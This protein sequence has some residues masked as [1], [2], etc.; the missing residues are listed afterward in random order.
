MANFPCQ[1][2]PPC[3]I[4]HH[5]P[6]DPVHHVGW[7]T[8]HHAERYRALVEKLRNSNVMLMVVA[9]DEMYR[10]LLAYLEVTP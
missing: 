1:A 4:D 5:G 6:D 3:G 2:S 8:I 7:H 10:A 9:S